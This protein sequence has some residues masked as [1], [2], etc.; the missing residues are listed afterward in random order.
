MVD[1][2]DDHGDFLADVH[3]F[4]GEVA[5]VLVAHQAVLAARGELDEDAEVGGAGD[6][7]RDYVSHFGIAGEAVHAA[8]SQFDHGLIVGGDDDA[9]VVGNVDAAARLLLDGADDA[10]A[11]AD[12][13]ADLL[14]GDLHADQLG[15]V[16]AHLGP[17][18]GDGPGHAVEDMQAADAGLLQSL[19]QEFLGQAVDLDVHLQGVDALLGSG[20]LEVHIAEEVLDALDVAED[21]VAVTV[22]VGDQAHGDT[23]HRSPQGN[24]GVPEGHGRAADAAHGRGA[25]GGQ[26][27]AHYAH[28]VREV[29]LG[30][31]GGQDRPFRERS[32]S[33][34]PPARRSHPPSL[35]DAVGREVVVVHELLGVLGAHGVQG[36]LHGQ[37]GQRGNGEHLGLSPGEQ[38][39]AVSAGQFADAAGNG[40][41]LVGLAAVGSHVLVEDAAAHFLFDEILESLGD[42]AA[43]I[44]VGQLRGNLRLDSVQAGVALALEGVALQYLGDA[45]VDQGVDLALA[46]FGR[47]VVEVNLGLVGAALSHQ[48]VD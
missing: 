38:A 40:P 22:G 2:V 43:G 14:D 3:V 15:G 29:F 34:F 12:E 20:N 4:V 32:V 18:L 19:A 42:I 45:S 30:G 28:G 36:L 17:G 48:L 25:V 6:F 24:A 37:R 8:A 35:A 10:P 33:D 44:V 21:G 41:Y 39:A 11:G 47:R 31:H 27:L 26:H 23:G 5:Q 7:A 46:L 9:A 16:P 1:F 13:G